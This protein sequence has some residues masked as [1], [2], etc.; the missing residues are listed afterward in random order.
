M[1]GRLALAVLIFLLVVP[2]V[3]R[4]CSCAM[5]TNGCGTALNRDSTV[6][7]GQVIS[8]D[9]IRESGNGRSNGWPTGYAFHFRTTENFQGAA[10]AVKR[11]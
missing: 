11:W 7:L 3:I 1:L 5:G 10:E 6:F 8:R 9:E 2:S 4:A